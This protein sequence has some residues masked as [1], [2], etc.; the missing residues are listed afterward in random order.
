MRNLVAA[1]LFAI[2]LVVLP[3]PQA[4]ADDTSYVAGLIK[5]GYLQQVQTVGNTTTVIVGPKFDRL[6]ALSAKEVVCAAVLRRERLSNSQVGELQLTYPNGQPLG[7]FD[8]T[9]LLAN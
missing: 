3:L 1:F 7:R 6:N 5:K 4:A 8:G 9:R 2:A